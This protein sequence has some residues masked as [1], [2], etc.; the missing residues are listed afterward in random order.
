MHGVQRFLL[1]TGFAIDF[2]LRLIIGQA[3]AILDL[4][5][6]IYAQLNNITLTVRKTKTMT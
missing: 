3:R 5:A 6:K 2:A 1:M 4:K